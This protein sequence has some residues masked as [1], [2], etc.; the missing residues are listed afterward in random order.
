MPAT[1][2]VALVQLVVFNSHPALRH[3]LGGLQPEGWVALHRMIDCPYIYALGR[4]AAANR[5]ISNDWIG[6]AGA[7]YQ[8]RRV[9]IASRGAR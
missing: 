1:R 5:R 9:R 8:G 3:G 4:V 2:L 6:P 7:H